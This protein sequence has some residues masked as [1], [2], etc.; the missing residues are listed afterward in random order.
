MNFFS[1]MATTA[2]VAKT[3]ISPLPDQLALLSIIL[4][5]P[6]AQGSLGDLLHKTPSPEFKPSRLLQA[7]E[8]PTSTPTIQP[9]PVSLPSP[10]SVMNARRLRKNHYTIALL[11]DSMID[12]L[13]PGV[14]SLKKLLTITYPGVTFTVANFG[15]GATNIEYGIERITNAYE[16]LG[17][18]I[19]ALVD[20]HPDIVVVESF[21]YNPLPDS[22]GALDRHWMDLAYVVDKVKITMPEAKIIIAAT[23]APNWDIFG[24]GTPGLS[25]TPEEK[26]KRVVT[27]KT[28]LDNAV[29]FAKSQHLP[30]A[31]VFHA[32]LD[33]SGNGKAIYI[34]SS[35][36]IHYSEAGKR[37]FAKKVVETVAGSRLLE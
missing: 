23:I 31:D 33:A 37:L 28:Y 18:H 24:D 7:L 4:S 29:R 20:S 17:Q 25:F 16:Y 5:E 35:D 10:Q 34:N 26:R 2:M 8:S 11:G 15:V 9:T 6:K 27:I 30:L 19:Q 22:E 12:T 14:P 13:G 3:L 32:S 36:H 1:L 21:G